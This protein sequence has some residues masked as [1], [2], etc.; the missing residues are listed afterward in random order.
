MNPHIPYERLLLK[1]AF[2]FAG[3]ALS[4][5][6]F[7]VFTKLKPKNE[8]PYIGAAYSKILQGKH[9]EAVKLLQEKALTLNPK[10]GSAYA[11]MGLALR[12][13]DKVAESDTA[14]ASAKK[15]DDPLAARLA[16]S[17][18]QMKKIA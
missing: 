15:C 13:Q 2:A 12:L 18:G 11:Y 1:I 17:I 10:S 6:I 9:E 4:D 3:S 14:L 16:D 5:S 7:Q 8:S